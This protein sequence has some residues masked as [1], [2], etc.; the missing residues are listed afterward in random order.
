M[1]IAIGNLQQSFT[2]VDSSAGK[3]ILGGASIEANFKL[4][5]SGN[6]SKSFVRGFV[7]GFGKD[8]SADIT[9]EAQTRKGFAGSF[10]ALRITGN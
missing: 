2:E 1:K 5:A 10:S 3:S 7:L 6:N 4:S 9:V 8:L